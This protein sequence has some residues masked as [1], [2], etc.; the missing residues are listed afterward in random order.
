[1]FSGP[2][3]ARKQYFPHPCLNRAK[4]K[5]DTFFETCWKD[6]KDQR[7]PTIEPRFS[8]RMAVEHYVIIFKDLT[9]TFLETYLIFY[10]VDLIMS[11][12]QVLLST[13]AT[14]VKASK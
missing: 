10:W 11:N 4:A 14:E 8:F 7:F 2:H 12:K 3:V 6:A 1:M 9:E 13:Q 5:I